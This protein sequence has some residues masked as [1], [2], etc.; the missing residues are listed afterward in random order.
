[1]NRPSLVSNS[2]ADASLLNQRIRVGRYVPYRDPR[3]Y[4]LFSLTVLLNRYIMYITK[5][6]P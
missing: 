2:H 1:M 3:L 5:M 4:L 6:N